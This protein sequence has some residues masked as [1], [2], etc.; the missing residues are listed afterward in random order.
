[1]NPQNANIIGI[2]INAP[3][4]RSVPSLNPC[5]C[6]DVI[7]PLVTNVSIAKP[8]KE[9]MIPAANPANPPIIAFSFA[10]FNTFIFLSFIGIQNSQLLNL[11]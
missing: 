3:N 9:Y 8:P 2:P 6:V 1:M 5:V 11:I 4:A 10:V 7:I